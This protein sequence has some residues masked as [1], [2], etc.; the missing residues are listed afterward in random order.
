MIGDHHNTISKMVI[1]LHIL[2]DLD[3]NKPKRKKNR[4]ESNKNDVS[5]TSVKE[6]FMGCFPPLSLPPP[7]M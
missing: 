6:E 4:A 1:K 2:K 5:D 3:A 7:T